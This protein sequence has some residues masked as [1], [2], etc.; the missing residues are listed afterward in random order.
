MK[1]LESIKDK[2]LI[3]AENSFKSI[4]LEEMNQS[5]KLYNVKFMTILEYK[6]NLLFDYDIKTINYLVSKYKMKVSNAISLINNLYYIEN[7]EYQNN[8][9]NYLVSIKNELD[10][11]NLLIYNKYFK[12]YLDSV[13][14]IVYGYDNLDKFSLSLLK[15]AI[16]INDDL[17]DKKINIYE[18]NNISNEVEFVFNKISDLLINGIDINKIKLAN[19]TSEYIPYLKRFSKYYNIEVDLPSESIYGTKFVNDFLELIKSGCSK[20]EIV[21]KLDS[22]KES[23]LYSVIINLINNYVLFDNLNDVYEL[24]LYDIKNIKLPKKNYKNVIE[25]INLSDYVNSDEYVFLLGFNNGNIPILYKDEDYI[26]D[27][28]KDEV[29]MS[30]TDDLNRISNLNTINS[31]KR[32][33][34]LYISYKL[35][36]PFN[37]YFPSNLI[38]ELDCE[39]IK[40]SSNSFNYSDVYNKIKYT[41]YLD[42]YVKYGEYNQDL[43]LLYNNYKTMDYSS[44]DNCYKGINKES[45]LNY[46]DNKLTLSYSSIDN[47]YKC[48]F[49][50]YLSNILK[51][52]TFEE[53]FDTIIGNIFHY[54]LSKAFNNNFDFLKEFNYA[55]KDYNFN[56][57]ENFFINK[58]KKDLIFIIETIKEYQVNTGLTKELYEQKITIPINS[59]PNVEFKG[60]IDKIMYKEKDGNTYLSI[61]DYKTGNPS[62]KLDYLKYGLSMQ[63]PSYLYLTSKSN[64]FNNIKYCGF[65]LQHI[66]DNE[67]KND[68]KKSFLE[69]KKDNL[70]LQGYSTSDVV[71]LSMF[72]DSYEDSKMIK[73][74][75]TKIDGELSAT[76]KVLS[77]SEIND[78]INLCEEKIKDAI[79]NILNGNFDINPKII[80]DDNIGCKYCHFKDICYHKEKDNVYLEESEVE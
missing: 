54:V 28:I 30:N 52:D 17:L 76:S 38:D 46:L 44:Y 15:D 45:L 27:N 16:F 71:R 75:K 7:K 50:Y 62:I 20:E 69:Q 41:N 35:K 10:D 65:Y 3:I 51:V 67:I 2:T 43:E 58:L 14:I 48:G 24:I 22:Y 13:K 18:F 64:L 5:K 49:R 26:T 31:L 29:I 79:K 4:I 61:I 68:R 21:G 8:K 19:V 11:K 40:E 70:K 63:L 25:I 72:D 23:N 1:L 59:N 53:T 34:N 56:N 12:N 39:I 74:I 47:F 73:G 80:K 66:L 6:K 78:I 36:T 55:I 9:L 33:N 60:F 77:D 32:I 37:T 42:E 57:M